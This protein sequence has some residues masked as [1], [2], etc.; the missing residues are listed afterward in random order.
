MMSNIDEI[1]YTKIIESNNKYIIKY[2]EET[3]ESYIYDKIVQIIQK[4]KN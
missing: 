4:K 2:M 1:S 3:S